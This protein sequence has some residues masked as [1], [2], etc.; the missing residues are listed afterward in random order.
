MKL[1]GFDFRRSL[2]LAALYGL[3][4]IGIVASGGG[5]GG[6]NSAGGGTGA[7]IVASFTVSPSSGQA[8]L[9]ITFDA[10]ASRT[11]QG[12]L[13]AYEWEF[14]D[15]ATATT[16]GPSTTH[17][18][19]AA[20]NLVARLT[21]RTSGNLSAT[22]TRAIAVSGSQ[23]TTWLG[24][25]VS[26]L[27]AESAVRADLI[28]SGATISG[29]YE[30]HEGRTGT[31]EMTIS[32]V[33]VTAELMETTP[34][35]S[36]LFTG[37]GGYDASLGAALVLIGFTGANCDGQHTAGEL[38]L[39][40]QLA[41]VL[42]WGHEGL[43][44][45]R[46]DDSE[47]LFTDKSEYPLKK[48]STST[49]AITPLGYAMRAVSSLSLVGN[50]LLWTDFTDDVG[51]TGCLGAGAVR[52]L[53]RAG[54]NGSNPQRLAEGDFCS[55][56]IQES[57]LSDGTYAYWARVDGT[58]PLIERVPLVGGERQRIASIAYGADVLFAI[59][60][61]DI[62]WTESFGIG[63]SNAIKRCPLAGCGMANPTVV[64]QDTS[65]GIQGGI[66]LNGGEIYVGLRREG[67]F[68]PV[69]ARVSKSGGVLV[70]LVG[71]ASAR[72]LTT[73]GTSLFW[74]D[75]DTLSVSQIETAPIGGGSPVPLAIDIQRMAG[76]VL[77]PGYAYWIEGT[78][79]TNQNDGKVRRVPTAGGAVQTIKLDAV[80]PAFVQ[81]DH[82]TG[83][84]VYAD[85]GTDE[86]REQGI[87]RVTLAGV[88]TTLAKGIPSSQ[89]FAMSASGVFVASGFSVA[90]LSRSGLGVAKTLAPADFPVQA[91]ETDG[92][93]IYWLT[94]DPFGNV[95]SSPPTG[96]QNPTPLGAANG[97]ATQLRQNGTDLFINRLPDTLYRLPKTGGGVEPL[98]GDLDF[99]DEF[100][101]DDSYAYVVESDSRIITRIDLATQARSIA[102]SGIPPFTGWFTLAHD[103][104]A[105]YLMSPDALQRYSKPGGASS[106]PYG[107]I[108]QDDF[109]K[110]AEV[111]L[112]DTYIYWVDTLLGA[113]LRL[114]K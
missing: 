58:G 87:R 28:R 65:Y 100:V 6:G 99:P 86:N 32:G 47:L 91:I 10:S 5:G 57:V 101:V 48:I 34:G 15:G 42:S 67:S 3:G 54:A 4:I 62:Y 104:G 83:A 76:L 61:T 95:V 66:V 12:T 63:E 80:W 39:F 43:G 20:A 78:S 46:V 29:T 70:D 79:G 17:Q 89:P 71:D 45:L 8:P 23:Q 59:D 85:G 22:T 73:D 40:E 13:T 37:S 44:S 88:T 50:T 60:A 21:V 98:A 26:D 27:Y 7:T 11:S 72:G 19:M 31:L 108:Y 24:G 25:Y 109:E 93:N 33:V 96:T 111:A 35:C 75:T 77:G 2:A 81:F 92:T 49:G 94:S 113:V 36:G 69:I 38:V 82:G 53:V 30:D 51:E 74:W 97:F 41:E 16:A 52:A 110:P 103:S 56:P 9:T 107:P 1:H 90:S 84:V 14:G 112:D 68:A 18:Y 102:A 64:T 114:P 55:A 105:L 106:E